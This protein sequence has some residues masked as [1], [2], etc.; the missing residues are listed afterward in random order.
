MVKMG[1]PF[2]LSWGLPVKDMRATQ[3]AAVVYE[4]LAKGKSIDYAV[5]EARLSNRD[6]YHPWPLMRLFCDGTKCEGMVEAGLKGIRTSSRLTI[7][8][9][10]EGSNVQILQEGYQHYLEI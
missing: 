3:F 7:H 6:N 9:N 2:V 4:K 8:K 5:A 10:L 1:V